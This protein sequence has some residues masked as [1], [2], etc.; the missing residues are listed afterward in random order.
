MNRIPAGN[1]DGGQWTDDARWAETGVGNTVQHETHRDKLD[2]QIRVAA[3]F[4]W[5][6]DCDAQYERDLFQCRMV[7]LRG[8][9]EQAM[10]RLIACG[11]GHTIPPLNY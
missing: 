6:E 9:Y 1:P 10:V 8:C 7:G 5:N 3:R 2:A 11:K 4:E